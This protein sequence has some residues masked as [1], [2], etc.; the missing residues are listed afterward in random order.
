MER[1]EAILRRLTNPALA[2]PTFAKKKVEIVSVSDPLADV[3]KRISER[4]YSQFPVYDGN[5]FKGL[6]TE[7]G[8]TRWLAHHVSNELSLVE[9]ADIPVKK[10][11]REEEK[12]PN[13]LFVHRNKPVDKIKELFA[14][15]ELLE[16]VLITYSGNRSENLL[17][18]ATRWDII[19]R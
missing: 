2:I 7:N 14:D 8:I 10:A 6:L 1:L 13:W 18:I 4:D 12:R 19:Q 11:L 5:V 3:L 16:A 17:C 9:L 15:H